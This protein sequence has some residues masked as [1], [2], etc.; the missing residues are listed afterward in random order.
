M[1]FP[2]GLV[3]K[4][5]KNEV[6]KAANIPRGVTGDKLYLTEEICTDV[7]F[8]GETCESKNIHCGEQNQSVCY[9]LIGVILLMVIQHKSLLSKQKKIPIK[10]KQSEELKRKLKKPFLQ[11]L[12]QNLCLCEKTEACIQVSKKDVTNFKSKRKVPFARK[13]I[14]NEIVNDEQGPMNKM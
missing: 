7:T 1:T 9:R 3:E 13:E 6:T 2:C 10:N 11:A 8:R 4:N 5:R 12:S 14:V